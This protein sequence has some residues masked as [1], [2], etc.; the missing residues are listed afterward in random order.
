MLNEWVSLTHLV[1]TIVNTKSLLVGTR[2][3]TLRGRDFDHALG[4]AYGFHT[5]K[6]KHREQVS[7]LNTLY[8]AFVSDKPNTLYFIDS[9]NIFTASFS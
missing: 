8:L 1:G 3:Y 6:K 4:N 9:F 2:W 5:D 7:V